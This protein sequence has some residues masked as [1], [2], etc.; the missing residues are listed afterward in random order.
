M[1]EKE[2]PTKVKRITKK[3]KEETELRITE[4][5]Q[6][7]EELRNTEKVKKEPK[8][9]GRKRLDEHGG[10]TKIFTARLGADSN[11]FITI[12]ARNLGLTTGELLRLWCKYLLGPGEYEGYKG[13]NFD[14]NDKEKCLEYY[15]EK[16]RKF[17]AS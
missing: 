16:L 4:S 11:A 8:K 2:N 3:K 14:V 15:M 5:G 13:L 1:T 12:T 7:P 10:R 6:P 17:R 9:R